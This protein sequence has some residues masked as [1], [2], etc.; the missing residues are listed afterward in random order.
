MKITVAGAAII[1]AAVIGVIL[2]LRFLFGGNGQGPQEG[3]IQ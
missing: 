1:I 2:L 3:D